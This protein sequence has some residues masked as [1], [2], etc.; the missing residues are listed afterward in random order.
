MEARAL[1]HPLLPVGALSLS[2][3]ARP[4]FQTVDQL[5]TGYKKLCSAQR[6]TTVRVDLSSAPRPSSNEN[7][8]GAVEV[9]LLP[10]D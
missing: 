1:I 6:G 2:K 8:H 3:C 7:F 4:N 9:V 5:Q 10:W